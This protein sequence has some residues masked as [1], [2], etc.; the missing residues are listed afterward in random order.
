MN[1]VQNE[2]PFCGVST[3]VKDSAGLKRMLS[4]G[5]R[6]GSLNNSFNLDNNSNRDNRSSK[7]SNGSNT[8]IQRTPLQNTNTGYNN[9]DNVKKYC[10]ITPM[11]DQ[12]RD[13]MN[14]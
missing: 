14:R 4:S 1:R 5:G 8:T 3:T 10:A 6:N 7:Y 13:G 9:P 11:K 2:S 12:M